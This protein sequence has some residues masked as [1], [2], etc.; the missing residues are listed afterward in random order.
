MIAL[1]RGVIAASTKTGSR[2]HESGRISTN[3]GLAPKYVMGAAEAIQ[4]VSGEPHVQ[5]ARAARCGN[6]KLGSDKGTKQRLKAIN[7]F[8]TPRAPSVASSVGGQFDLPFGDRWLSIEDAGRGHR[9]SI[10]GTAMA[11]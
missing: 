3:T 2:H 9:S 5:G 4:L 6:G 11:K 7:V 8:I 1:V 10:V